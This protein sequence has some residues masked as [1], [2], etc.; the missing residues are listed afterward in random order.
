MSSTSF[1]L[2]VRPVPDAPVLKADYFDVV[3]GG[4]SVLLDPLKNDRDADGDA[5]KIVEIGKAARGKVKLAG[6]KVEYTAPRADWTGI[7]TFVI[8]VSDGAG[9][10]GVENVFV[11]VADD[12][13]LVRID[14]DGRGQMETNHGTSGAASDGR[15]NLISRLVGCTLTSTSSKGTLMKSTATGKRPL[16]SRWE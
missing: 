11:N 16:T 13:P 9:H 5:L 14:F 4:E 3:R 6:D 10:T 15:L 8:T 12:R 1:T 7:D 2:T